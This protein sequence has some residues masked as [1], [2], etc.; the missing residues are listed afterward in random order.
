MEDL[1]YLRI[2]L[3]TEIRER[4]KG[5]FDEVDFKFDP[6]HNILTFIGKNIINMYYV[7]EG[8]NLVKWRIIAG[9]NEYYSKLDKLFEYHKLKTLHLS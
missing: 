6:T 3:E 5:I 7:E 4:S 1:N 8:Y 9:N 2:S